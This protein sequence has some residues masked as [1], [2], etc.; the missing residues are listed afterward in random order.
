MQKQNQLQRKSSFQLLT[1]FPEI[2][3]GFLTT[4]LIGKAIERDLISI[5]TTNIRDYADPPHKRVDD[6]PYGGGAGMVMMAE[7]IIRAVRDLK[8]R[9]PNAK[10]ICTSA[11]GESFTQKK[12]A[13]LS[14]VSELII[15]CGR[16]E[17][18]DQRAI[19]LVVDE[20]IS[21]GDYVIMG[22]EVASMVIIEAL[23][24]LIPG[25]LG[26]QESVSTESFQKD[27]LEAPQY[28]KPQTVE[29]KDVP[30]ILL[31]GDH[32]KIAEWREKESRAATLRIKGKL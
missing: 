17:G 9:S 31:S 21:I 5:E 32:K 24:R 23:T 30:N 1:I 29:G 14:Q 19:E 4:S 16:Y 22:G 6:T 11:R 13:E 15:L 28:T 7:P 2:F 3:N 25:V 20:E 27:L 12:A 26:N 8:K 18:I 10:V